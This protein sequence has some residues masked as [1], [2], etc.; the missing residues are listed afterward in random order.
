MEPQKMLSMDILQKWWVNVL[1]DEDF[2]IGEKILDLENC[3]RIIISDLTTSF[4]EYAKEHNPKHRLWSVKRFCGQFRK[5]VSNVEVK[6]SGSGPREYEFPSLNDCKLFFAEK[7][8]L[9]SDVFEIS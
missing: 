1:S 9:D 5:L 7:Y 2:T 4:D 8:S 3:N 6:R